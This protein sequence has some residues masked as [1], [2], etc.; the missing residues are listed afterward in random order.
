MDNVL[1]MMTMVAI[2]TR[3]SIILHVH[4]KYVKSAIDLYLKLYLTIVID[5]RLPWVLHL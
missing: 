3:L 2:L 1:I 5:P 4:N